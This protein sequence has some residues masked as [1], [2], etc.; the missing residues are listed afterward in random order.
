MGT[1]SSYDEFMRR[2]ASII[3]ILALGLT[4]GASS[5]T[6]QPWAGQQAARSTIDDF[7]SFDSNFWS[8]LSRGLRTKAIARAVQEAP[9]DP[10]TIDLVIDQPYAGDSFEYADLVLDA[11]GRFAAGSSDDV[12]YAARVITRHWR[13]IL[14]DE[15]QERSSGSRR[16]IRC[17]R[18]ERRHLM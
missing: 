16:F 8:V 5:A 2:A 13:D 6:S 10:A 3:L 17:V 15:S 4:M 12:E 1:T 14:R 7:P 9:Y 18:P 11:L